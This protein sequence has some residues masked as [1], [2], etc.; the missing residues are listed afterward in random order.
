MVLPTGFTIP[1]DQWVCASAHPARLNTLLQSCGSSRSDYS[2]LN[3]DDA[4]PLLSHACKTCFGDLTALEFGV[5][6]S[7]GPLAYSAVLTITGP[8][9]IGIEFPDSGKHSTQEL[10]KMHAAYKAILEGAVGYIMQ[11]AGPAT[12]DSNGP[13]VRIP[14]SPERAINPV[15]NKV[16]PD[17]TRGMVSTVKQ[18]KK[19]RV[20]PNLKAPPDALNLINTFLQRVYRDHNTPMTKSSREWNVVFFGGGVTA[21]LT[22]RL[23]SGRSISYGELPGIISEPGKHPKIYPSTAVA[24]REVASDALEA[25][26]LQ[27]IQFDKQ[28]E[29]TTLPQ[30]SSPTTTKVRAH[31]PLSVYVAYDPAKLPRATGANLVPLSGVARTLVHG[32]P[33]RP[34]LSEHAVNMPTQDVGPVP[35]LEQVI[36]ESETTFSCTTPRHVGRSPSPVDEVEAVDELL[37][38]GSSSN[39][40]SSERADEAEVDELASSVCENDSPLSEGLSESME[41]DSD[42]GSPKEIAVAYPETRVSLPREE[43][44]SA[45]EP[46]YKRQRTEPSESPIR[47]PS[48]ELDH[49]EPKLML[50]TSYRAILS[51]FCFE[52]G[53]AQ[54]QVTYQRNIEHPK[55]DGSM[56]YNVSITLG[57]SRF[58]L[59]KQY[60]SIELAE[61]KLSRRILRQFGVRAKKT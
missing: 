11:G 50:G 48:Q 7:Q 58:E 28:E 10:A 55:T 22:I 23:P 9:E 51:E 39:P 12:T 53:H 57:T 45:D 46:P 35:P 38:L 14:T 19:S 36:E 47:G 49:Q 34:C 1:L 33:P 13:S 60:E 59:S 16:S 40:E 29:T 32:L 8:D 52:R 20:K 42:T 61:E 4:L 30:P 26:V 31:N 5:K 24:K 21:R 3:I 43:P 27:F 41:L 54:P 56:M 44:E 18:G 17:T 37:G 15:L 25:G 6:V 2:H